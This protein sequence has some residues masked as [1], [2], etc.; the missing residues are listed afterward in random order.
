MCN[1]LK[2]LFL[3]L[4]KGYETEAEYVRVIA[5]WHEASDGRGVSQLERCHKNYD[6]LNYILDDL[7]PWHT[8]TYDLS[9]LDINRCVQSSNIAI[10]ATHPI[11]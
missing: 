6:M 11:H 5:S 1:I 2:G 8:E 4:R 10:M 7:M 9:L 3:F